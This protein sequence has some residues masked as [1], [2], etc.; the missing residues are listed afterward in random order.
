MNSVR[1][2]VIKTPHAVHALVRMYGHTVLYHNIP[3]WTQARAALAAVTGDACLFV[4]RPEFPT[5]IVRQTERASLD[6]RGCGSQ[7]TVVLPV[8][9]IVRDLRTQI[10]D[11][12]LAFFQLGSKFIMVG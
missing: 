5:P 10:R 1:G 7:H 8:G 9:L 3:N 12:L 6:P 2:A 4:N 11:L